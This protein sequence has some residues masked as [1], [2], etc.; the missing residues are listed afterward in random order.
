M[1]APVGMCTDGGFANGLTFA[2]HFSGNDCNYVGTRKRVPMKNLDN[3]Q[4]VAEIARLFENVRRDA[5]KT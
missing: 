4:P 2:D 3:I 5:R 1:H